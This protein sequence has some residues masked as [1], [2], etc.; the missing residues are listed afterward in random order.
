MFVLDLNQKH[1]LVKAPSPLSSGSEA[2]STHVPEE[3]MDVQK[4]YDTLLLTHPVTLDGEVPVRNVLTVV[5]LTLQRRLCERRIKAQMRLRVQSVI[6]K[7]FVFI[8]AKKSYTAVYKP[9][10]C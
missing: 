8:L 5:S 2:E 10:D 4:A 1:S 7:Y 3:K 9:E 6:C